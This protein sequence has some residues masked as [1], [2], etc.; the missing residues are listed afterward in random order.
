M[1]LIRDSYELSGA[2][3][4]LQK[5]RDASILVTGEDLN[6]TGIRVVTDLSILGKEGGV[7]TVAYGPSIRGKTTAHSDNEWID[8][9][10][11]ARVARTLAVLAILYCGIEN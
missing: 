1:Q 9:D 8:S 6:V 7:P 2:E 3:D 5:L 11:L 4:L 10:R